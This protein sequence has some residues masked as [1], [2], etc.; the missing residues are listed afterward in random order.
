MIG[1]AQIAGGAPS[2]VSGMTDH[3]LNQ[4]LKQE[5]ARLA[6]YYSG[7]M[8]PD[9]EMQEL[10]TQVADS[11]LAFPAALDVLV[12][13]YVQDGGDLDLLHAA[14]ERVSYQTEGLASAVCTASAVPRSVRPL[15]LEPFRSHYGMF[16]TSLRQQDQTPVGFPAA[17]ATASYSQPCNS[18]AR[19]PIG[20]RPYRA[21]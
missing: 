5:Q 4:T 21:A 2:S 20:Y 1:F 10:A 8:V 13:R 7:G 17:P 11:R 16:P 9:P 18:R 12:A 15:H 6:A 19:R 14:E 3:L